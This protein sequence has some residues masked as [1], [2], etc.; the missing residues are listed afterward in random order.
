MLYLDV[1]MK[2]SMYVTADFWTIFF[3]FVLQSEEER[4]KED[5]VVKVNFPIDL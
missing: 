5:S 2:L 3:F 4:I 1:G